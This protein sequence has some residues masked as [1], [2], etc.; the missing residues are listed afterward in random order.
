MEMTARR[1]DMIKNIAI[2]FLTVLLVLTFFSSTILNHSLPEVAAQYAY[3][4]QITTSV[5]GTGVTEANENYQVILE[6]GRVIRSVAVR[7][8]AHVNEGDLLF[9]LEDGES[10]ELQAANDALSRASLEYRKWL[11]NKEADLEDR[12]RQIGYE[13]EDLTQLLKAGNQDAVKA[14]RRTI[15][16]LEAKLELA[17]AT[18]ALEESAYTEAVSRA[19]AVADRLAATVGASEIYAK[20]AGTVNNIAVSAGQTVAAHTVLAEIEQQERGYSAA[21]SLTTEQAKRV[22]VGQSATILYYWGET[23]EATV[24][25]IEPSQYDPQN[26]RI[27]TLLLHG[28]ITAGQSFTFSLGER[29]ANYDSVVPSSAIREDS[30]GRFVLVVE[31]KNTP[32]GN[33]YTAVLRDVEVIAEDDINAAVTGLSGS[34][35]VIVT[36]S[37]PITAGQQ[38]RLS[39]N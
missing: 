32:I 38:I 27:V 9:V 16:Q 12:Q 13:N 31:A 17:K 37:A 28:D 30:N 3:S 6:E 11:L 24:A 34:E 20:V 10:A 21:L 25:S 35:F 8:G 36:S 22:A 18:Y 26:T 23:P 15:E 14:K 5:R 39:D 33:R 4:G 29:S 2:L 7:R 1:K 19:Q